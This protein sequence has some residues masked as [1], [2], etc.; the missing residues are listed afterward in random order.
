MTIVASVA[1]ILARLVAL[2]AL[3]AAII[4]VIYVILVVF[5]A[6]HDNQIVKWV[7]DLAKP[8][9]WKFKG[10][11]TPKNPR[12]EVAVNDILAAVVYLVVGQVLARIIRLAERA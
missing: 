9:A 11:F 1:R 7:G 5:K 4:L 6:S 12:T 8:L 10:L 3:L 2:A